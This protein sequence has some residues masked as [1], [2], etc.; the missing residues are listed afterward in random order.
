MITI[1]TTA[2]NSRATV[3]LAPPTAGALR[4]VKGL[5][6]REWMQRKRAWSIPKALV[7]AAITMFVDQGYR[8]VVDGQIQRP[9]GANPFVDLANAM[10]PA[11]WRRVSTELAE[12]LESGDGD[13]RLAR[14]LERAVE[15]NLQQRR[16]AG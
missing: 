6:R 2:R 11:L 16:R 5:P 15:A 9:A 3:E 12:I 7:P 8:V 1:S 13:R 14:L 10:S 4:I